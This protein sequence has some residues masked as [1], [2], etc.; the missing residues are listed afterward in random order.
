MENDNPDYGNTGT[1]DRIDTLRRIFGDGVVEQAGYLDVADLN[2]S[3]DMARDIAEGIQQLKKK[4]HDPAAQ[5]DWIRQQ[6]PGLLVV[7]CLW[8]MD[9]DLL[10]K[11]R[12][13]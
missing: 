3:D 1:D 9:M 13:K 10:E 2:I 6:P 4:R 8:I 5:Q 7:L 11:I 12:D